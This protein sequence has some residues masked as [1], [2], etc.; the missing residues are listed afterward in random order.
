MK[1]IEEVNLVHVLSGTRCLIIRENPKAASW[2]WRKMVK[3]VQLASPFSGDEWG[4]RGVNVMEI[5]S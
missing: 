5:S 1:D 3:R 2:D 4:R